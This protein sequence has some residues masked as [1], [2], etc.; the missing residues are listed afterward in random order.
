MLIILHD[1]M[2]AEDEP[3]KSIDNHG[4]TVYPFRLIN[5]IAMRSNV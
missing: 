1:S 3:I 5:M 2:N 4:I